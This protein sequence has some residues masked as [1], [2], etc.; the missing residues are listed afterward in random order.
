MIDPGERVVTIEDAAELQ[1]QQPHVCRSKRAPPNLEGHGEITMRDLREQRA[2]YASRPHHP[3]RNSRRGE[4][5]TCSQAMNTGHDGSMAT[6]HAN[7]PREGLTRLENM[8]GMADIKLP[9]KAMRRQIADRGASDRAG[10]PSCAT[11]RAASPSITEVV[12]MEGDVIMT[13]DL[14]KFE[15]L[16]ETADGK[17][18]GEYR[19]MGLRPYTLEK[20][21]QFG[22]DQPYLEACL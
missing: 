16:D 3:R 2:A 7:R 9:T 21:K 8:V 1:L 20:A 12:G 15:Y 10:Q 17:I 19:S 14:F 13:Q 6:I 5:S 22:F 18:I 11:A 4:R